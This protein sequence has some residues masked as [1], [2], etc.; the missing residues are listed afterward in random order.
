MMEQQTSL[1]IE[2]ALQEA[3]K[4]VRQ[5]RLVIEEETD[6]LDSNNFTEAVS[7]KKKKDDML[8]SYASL[9]E[10]FANRAEELKAIPSSLR[11]E[12][13]NE[14]SL[15]QQASEANQQA[16][17]RA[18]QITK[19]LSER[20]VRLAKQAVAKEGVNYTQYGTTRQSFLRPLHMQIN[21]TL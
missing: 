15:F 11:S 3:I 14:K 5:F 17:K 9:M 8:S 21:E 2:Q 12:I 10:S 1:P 13:D 16:L 4:T 19:R 6:A 18:G 20:M 7:L